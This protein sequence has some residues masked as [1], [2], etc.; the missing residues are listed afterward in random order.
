MSLELNMHYYAFD[1][2]ESTGWAKFGMDGK[3][4]EMGYVAYGEQ[5]FKF[6]EGLNPGFVV[7]EEFMLVTEQMAQGKRMHYSK[8]WDKV[9]TSR[10]IGAIEQFAFERGIPVYFQRSAILPLA[11]QAWGIPLT[12]F[13]MMQHPLDAILHGAWYAQQNLGVLPPNPA[14][15]EPVEVVDEIRTVTIGSMADI[16]K[17]ARRSRRRSK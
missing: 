12:G 6:L 17:A 11:S 16:A 3:P 14:V 7:C 13:K 1:P 15:V 4:V 5:L 8:P 9:I 2:G 10:A